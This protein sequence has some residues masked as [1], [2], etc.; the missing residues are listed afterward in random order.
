MEPE[1]NETILK[2]LKTI[3]TNLYVFFRATRKEGEDEQGWT[4]HGV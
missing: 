1:K 4:I 2:I 3:N